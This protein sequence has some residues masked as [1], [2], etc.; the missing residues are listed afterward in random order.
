MSSLSVVWIK[1]MNGCQSSALISVD[2]AWP[3]L[4]LLFV[5][6]FLWFLNSVYLSHTFLF[7]WCFL[8]IILLFLL[9]QIHTPL[10][11][12]VEE[13]EEN[14][15]LLLELNPPNPWDSEPRPPEDLAFGEVQVRKHQ[16]III[17]KTKIKLRYTHTHICIFYITLNILGCGYLGLTV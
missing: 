1:E 12:V 13:S 7:Q 8:N 11:L 17:L 2:I 16:I 5:S 10:V 9:I 3:K 4:A 15:L 14:E 6:D